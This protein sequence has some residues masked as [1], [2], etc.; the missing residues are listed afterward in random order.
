LKLS[1][2]SFVL[3]NTISRDLTDLGVLRERAAETPES[4]DE[5]ETTPP[6]ETPTE[7]E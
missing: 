1:N 6:Q 7:G 3:L 5:P 2:G 4:T